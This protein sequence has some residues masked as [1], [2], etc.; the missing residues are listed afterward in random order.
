EVR[1][2]RAYQVRADYVPVTAQPPG[3]TIPRNVVGLDAQGGTG[4]ARQARGRPQREVRL[5]VDSRVDGS[6]SGTVDPLG[7]TDQFSPARRD[8]LDETQ[9]ASTR[10]VR[11]AAVG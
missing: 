2:V 1:R 3:L 9:G 10:H 5:P 7:H 11:S 8:H 4:N 6:G